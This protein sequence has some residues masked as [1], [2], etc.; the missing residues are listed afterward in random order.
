MKWGF[1]LSYYRYIPYGFK[2][3]ASETLNFSQDPM[4]PVAATVT[5]KGSEGIDVLAVTAAA[6][7]TEYAALGCTLQQFFSSGSL[8]LQT[9]GPVGELQQQYTESMRGRN[10]II[11]AMF[12]P[13]KTLNLGFTY[14]S[15]LKSSFDSQLLVWLVDEEG[16]DLDPIVQTSLS[17]VRI[18]AQ[19]SLGVSWRPAAGLNLSCDYSVLD[20]R[21]GTIENYYAE[22]SVLPYPQKN[23]F[24]TRQQYVRNLRLGMEVS[25]PLRRILLHLRGG[26]NSEKQLA[27]D[28]S[29]EPLQTNG[30]AAGVGLEFSDTLHAEVAYQRQKADWLEDGYF[31]KNQ[32]VPSRFSADLLKFSLTYR[33]GRIFKE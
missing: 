29:G 28:R 26:W 27:A 25:V 11:G 1:A 16:N 8:Y 15:G 2:G 30:L 9:V 33:F 7:I 31:A 23:Y 17:R 21:D 10:F 3:S 24:D 5:F 14:H 13:F 22:G 18:P 6:A 19:Y 4:Q 20:W 12:R 32:A